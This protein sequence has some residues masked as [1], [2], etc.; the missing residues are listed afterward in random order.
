[1]MPLGGFKGDALQDH[2]HHLPTGNGSNSQLESGITVVVRD[3]ASDTATGATA[4]T[5][6]GVASQPYQGNNYTIA[7]TLETRTYSASVSGL[8]NTGAE[9]APRHTA[10]N[11][12]I[13]VY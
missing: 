8:F 7:S 2:Y 9:T 3:Y 11:Y 5:F 13:Y 10:L 12:Y 1:M 6:V 4:G